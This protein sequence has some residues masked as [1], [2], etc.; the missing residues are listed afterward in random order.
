MATQGRE[1]LPARRAEQLGSRSVRVSAYTLL[2]LICSCNSVRNGWLDPTILG[3]FDRSGTMEIRASLSLED[4]PSGI[5]G[6]SFPNSRDRELYVEEARI[7][8][9]DTLSIEVYEL[10]ERQQPFQAQMQVSSTGYVNLP[11]IGRIEA[12]GRTATDFEADIVAALKTGGILLQPQVTVNP[13]YL[14]RGTY[15]IF[16][17]GVSAAENAPL[18]AG[19]FPIRRPDMRMLEAINLVG[20]LN[21]FVT[22][23]Y[24]FRTWESPEQRLVAPPVIGAGAERR[25]NGMS[26]ANAA[27]GK[28]ILG[29][30]AASRPLDARF[31]GEPASVVPEKNE[32]TTVRRDPDAEILDVVERRDPL[33]RSR[34]DDA[35]GRSQ[36]DAELVPEAPGAYIF[37]NGEWVRNPA[38]QKAEIAPDADR[39]PM[40]FDSP[41]PAVNWSRVAGENNYRILVIPAE[42]LRAGDPDA[43][44]YIRPGDVVRIVSGEIGVYYVMGQVGRVGP[45]AFNAESVTLKSAIASAGGI[46]A[47]GWPDRCT[48]Y[49]RLGQ[50][51]QMIQV[52]VDRIFAGLD[53]DF[54]I[55]R[56]DIINVGTHPFAPFLERIRAWTLPNP[57]NNV[58]YS[59][60]YARNY[61]DIDSFSVRANP[62]NRPDLF[63]NLLP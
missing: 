60:T 37:A 15:S 63:P 2:L 50:R 13:I 54:Q 41:S 27:L 3:K 57:I 45:F 59:F 34:A 19:T 53:P 25:T 56:G 61:A 58:G 42:S 7:S 8:P 62:H 36:R 6:A 11:V 40:T 10:R 1:N 16:G 21:E 22:D 43:N 46:S 31:N 55:R 39:E 33:P 23:V 32:A 44:V 28:Q 49:R 51:E 20:G 26:E 47:L 4:T 5:P 35:I 48:I 9:G 14:N 17:I 12:N 52:N 18:R 24:V 38:Y 30:P 29:T